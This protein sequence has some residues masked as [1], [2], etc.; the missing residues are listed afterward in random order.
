MVDGVD[1]CTPVGVTLNWNGTSRH[2]EICGCLDGTVFDDVLD[3]RIYK[4]GIHYL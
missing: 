1:A 4:G 3:G 2:N